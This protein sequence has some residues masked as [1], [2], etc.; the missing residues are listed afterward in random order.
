M[1]ARIKNYSESHPNKIIIAAGDCNQLP[2]VNFAPNRV[3]FKT[4]ADQCIDTIFL[5]S[6]MLRIPKRLKSAEDKK[7]LVEIARGIF[8]KDIPTETT[9]RNIS[10]LQAISTPLI[11][12]PIKTAPVE[13]SPRLLENRL[14]R[15]LSMSLEKLWSVENTCPKEG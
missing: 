11:I 5:K 3:N 1:L 9:L 4:Y 8:D 13:R 2:P 6:M 14:E 7:L 10:A 15:S 12:L